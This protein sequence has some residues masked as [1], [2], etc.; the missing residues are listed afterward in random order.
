MGQAEAYLRLQTIIARLPIPVHITLGSHDDRPAFLEIFGAHHAAETGKVDKVI[1]I[2][3]YRI[4]M[5]D[6]SEPGRV[7]GVLEAGQIAWLQ[8]RLVEAMDRPVIVV[9]HHKANALHIEADTIHLLEPDAFIET[10]KTHPDIRQI[11][12]GHLHPTSTAM[13]RGLPFTTLAGGHYSVD[14]AIDRPM[15]PCAASPAPARWPSS[16]APRPDHGTVRRFHRRQC[17][18]HLAAGLISAVHRPGFNRPI[19]NG[20]SPT[21]QSAFR[22]S[23]SKTV[24]GEHQATCAIMTISRRAPLAAVSSWGESKTIMAENRHEACIRR[25]ST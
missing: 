3:G 25:V 22:Q 6:S 4:I 8:A 17:R 13:W 24:I 14:F 10:L 19:I 23:A 1:D 5:L 21:P 2:K 9:L 7:D 11:I 12:A 16:S 18:H 15:P 20:E